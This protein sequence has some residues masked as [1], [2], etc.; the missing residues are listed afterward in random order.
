MSVTIQILGESIFNRREGK[1]EP[2]K[3]NTKPFAETSK[4]ELEDMK[5]DATYVKIFINGEKAEARSQKG[6]SFLAKH[7]SHFAGDVV[8][9]AQKNG[10]YIAQA[11]KA[12]RDD[13]DAIDSIEA[14]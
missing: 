1:Y 9:K 4:D 8:S 6:L 10:W 7:F 2:N 14:Q 12:P 5:S 13:F 11:L 3:L